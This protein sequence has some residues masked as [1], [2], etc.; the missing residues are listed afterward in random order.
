MQDEPMQADAADS[1]EIRNQLLL[2]RVLA[3][4][5]L[6]G[7]V[8]F[9]GVAMAL[10]EAGQIHSPQAGDD[11]FAAMMIAIL[12]GVSALCLLLALIVRV[13]LSRRM[14]RAESFPE[15]LKASFGPL[16]MILATCESAGITSIVAIL[17]TGWR[18]PTIPLVFLAAG[19][20]L[21][22]FPTRDRLERMYHAARKAHLNL[23]ATRGQLK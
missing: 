17:L 7:I 8:V 15:A 16:V 18:F 22:N 4:A 23:Q 9:F 20:I 2:F 5:M 13:W 11:S 6:A 14:G 19:M 1:R 10:V 12:C 3:G 21:L